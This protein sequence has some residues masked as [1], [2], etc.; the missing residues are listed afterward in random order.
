MQKPEPSKLEMQVLAVLWQRGPATVRDVLEALPDGKTRAY[1]TVL[2]VM[3]VMEK[4]GLLK[5]TNQGN[6]HV[7]APKVTR[8]QA[9]GPSLRNLVRH[10]FGGSPAAAMQHLL[11]ESEITRDELDKIKLLIAEHEQSSRPRGGGSTSRKE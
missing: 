1:T 6:A 4:K 10:V 2:T 9:V 11:A 7:Y 5:H 8:K 3:Q